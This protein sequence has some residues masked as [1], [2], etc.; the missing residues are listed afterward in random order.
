LGRY[1]DIFCWHASAKNLFEAV[2]MPMP[3]R[4]IVI[5][6]C[7]LIC[8]LVA[9]CARGRPSQKRCNGASNNFEIVG[10]GTK[11]AATWRFLAPDE[12]VVAR[13]A[14]STTIWRPDAEFGSQQ[15]P[16]HGLGWLEG[17]VEIIHQA[18]FKRTWNE[19]TRSVP[20]LSE[21]L[22]LMHE[23]FSSQSVS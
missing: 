1:G 21:S 7:F 11:G 19:I 8:S 10:L 15:R 9:S 2:C 16:F 17:Y 6:M 3:V 18:I 4:H 5:V 12:L 14:E 22:D 13:G 23:L 20:T